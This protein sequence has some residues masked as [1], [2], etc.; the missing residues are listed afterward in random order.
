MRKL[1]EPSECEGKTIESIE[2]NWETLVI[3]FTDGST[4]MVESEIDGPDDSNI[5][6]RK[7][8]EIKEADDDMLREL[9]TYEILSQPEYYSEK[10]RRREQA[11]V[12]GHAERYEMFLKLQKEFDPESSLTQPTSLS[13]G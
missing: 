11:A 1:L 2:H 3:H 10:V 12:E 6:Y 9:F 7:V 5:Y 4:L 13:I 8:D